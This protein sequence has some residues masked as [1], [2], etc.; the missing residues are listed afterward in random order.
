MHLLGPFPRMVCPVKQIFP[1]ASAYV[2]DLFRHQNDPDDFSFPGTVGTRC[3]IW[4]G[5]SFQSLGLYPPFDPR[6]V[7]PSAS[8]RRPMGQKHFFT[9]S[10]LSS[11]CV[12]IL[13]AQRCK[14]SFLSDSRPIFPPVAQS[15]LV[16]YLKFPITEV[17][18]FSWLLGASYIA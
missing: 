18:P 6:V 5:N 17:P 3:A 13:L 4:I 14:T 2:C 8:G 11:P 10:H 9:Y 7:D 15:R 16:S 12:F 1:S